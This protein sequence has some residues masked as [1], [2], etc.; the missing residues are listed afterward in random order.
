VSKQII[1]FE[2]GTYEISP[3]SEYARQ[4]SSETL[5]RNFA[6]LLDGLV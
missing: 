5:A 6:N 3:L 2:N 1:R 4:F